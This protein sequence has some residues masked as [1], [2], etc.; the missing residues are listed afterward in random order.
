MSLRTKRAPFDRYRHPV[1][2]SVALVTALLIGVFLWRRLLW[3]TV[4]VAAGPDPLFGSVL[5]GG[6][7]TGSVFLAGLVLLTGAYTSALGIDRGVALPDRTGLPAVGLAVVVPLAFVAATKLVGVLTDVPYNSLTKTAVAAGASVRPVAL[8]AGLGLLISVPTLCL[9]CQVLVQGTFAQVVDGTEA[10]VLTT[11]VTG[12]AM[13][14]TAGGLATVP[15]RGKLAGTALFAGLLCAGVYAA[16]YADGERLRA[17]GY[18]P[19]ALFVAFVVVAGVASVDSIAGG[20]FAV[21]QLAVLGIAAVTSDRT[22]SLLPPAFAYAT[23][24]L[25]NRLVV[26]VFEPGV[27]SW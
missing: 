25:A 7:L 8:L 20:L 11:L 22:G 3:R 14:S 16:D 26:F 12:F 4:S 5:V 10:V 13:T 17:L 24:L 19:A 27:Q 6:L 18:V 15:D 9:V 1:A 23:L 21:T 2:V